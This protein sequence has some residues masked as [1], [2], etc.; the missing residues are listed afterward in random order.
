MTTSDQTAEALWEEMDTA[1]AAGLPLEQTRTEA[2]ATETTPPA[3]E[4]TTQAE[5]Q[6]A[7]VDATVKT[8]E[9]TAAPVD[10]YAGLPDPVKQELLGLKSITAQLQTRLRNAEGHIGG[11]N[12]QLRQ[13]RAAGVET[14]TDTQVKQ[15]MASSAKLEKLREDFP[16]F[17]A[18]IEEAVQTRAQ[19]VEDIA[20]IKRKLQEQEQAAIVKDR[21]MAVEQRHPGWQAEVAGPQ[22]RGWLETAPPEYKILAASDDPALA[23]RLLDVYKSASQ[24]A[25]NKQALASAAAIPNRGAQQVQR[26]KPVDEMTPEELWKY[27]DAQ[28]RANS[29]K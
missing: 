17:A 28:D 11:L 20:E 24:P 15:A 25:G 1:E 3:A 19:P 6:G 7:T 16:E 13:A 21:Y 23:I 4:Q 27:L 18:A 10:P 5:D 26:S 2:Q 29:R 14:P 8:P 12:S 9:P 22:F